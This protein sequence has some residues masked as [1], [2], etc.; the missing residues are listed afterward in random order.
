MNKNERVIKAIKMALEDSDGVDV[1]LPYEAVVSLVDHFE[2]AEER[3]NAGFQH[4]EELGRSIQERIAAHEA[5]VIH[6]GE[7]IERK[8]RE[9]E[10][11]SAD[12]LYERVESRM[13]GQFEYYRE[14]VRDSVYDTVSRKLFE[15]IDFLRKD[16]REEIDYKLSVGIIRKNCRGDEE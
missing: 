13:E 3:F 11:L 7:V 15:E 14:D 6:Q 16:L 12:K 9:V 1:V 2:K 8:V 5:L 10:N 4:M